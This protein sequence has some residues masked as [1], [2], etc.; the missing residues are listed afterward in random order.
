MTE[1]ALLAFEILYRGWAT[2]GIATL[3]ERDG[4]LVRRVLE[5]HGEAAAVLPYDP[6][7]RMALLVRQIRVGPVFR[8]EA[9]DLVEVPAGGLDDDAPEAAARRE[10]LEETGVQVRDLQFVAATYTMPGVS[11]ERLHLFLAEYTPADRVSKGGGLDNEGE[12]ILVD[13]V[14]LAMLAADAA[15][16]RVADLKTLALIQ[17]LQLRRPDLFVPQRSQ[18]NRLTSAAAAGI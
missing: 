10:T 5:D 15:A 8:G 14:P 4:S 18:P 1:A 2:F 13:E 9:G 7:R 17:A 11:S 3:A 16:G 12:H 6:E